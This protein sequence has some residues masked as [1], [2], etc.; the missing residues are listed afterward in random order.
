MYEE[1]TRQR[2]MVYL[3]NKGFHCVPIPS[4]NY[5]HKFIDYLV[6]CLSLTCEFLIVCRLF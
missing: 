6:K 5:F 4:K 1:Q 2:P 3:D